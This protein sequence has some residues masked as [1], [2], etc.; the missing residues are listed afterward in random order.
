MMTQNG[1]YEQ[2]TTSKSF[3][4][5]KDDQNIPPVL[6]SFAGVDINGPQRGQKTKEAKR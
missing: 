6:N 4:S 1:F 3:F 5:Q 2:K